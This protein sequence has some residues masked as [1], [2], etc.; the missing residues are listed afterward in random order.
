MS[1]EKAGFI[2]LNNFTISKN[3]RTPSD[4]RRKEA[5]LKY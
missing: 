4:N 1:Y 3:N 2:M 5:M